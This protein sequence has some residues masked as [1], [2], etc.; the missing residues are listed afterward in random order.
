[1]LQTMRDDRWCR[2]KVSLWCLFHSLSRA[3]CTAKLPYF[4]SS[5]VRGG[6]RLLLMVA[7]KPWLTLSEGH[8]LPKALHRHR[9]GIYCCARVGLEYGNQ[10]NGGDTSAVFYISSQS[11]FTSRVWYQVVFS[12]FGSPAL[13]GGDSLS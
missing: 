12:S 1:M 7:W 4:E 6:E 13:W 9:L 8:R 2:R 3:W 5:G 10:T 11:L